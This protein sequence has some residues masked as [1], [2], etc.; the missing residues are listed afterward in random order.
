M[1]TQRKTGPDV[2]V[3][4]HGSIALLY[5]NRR[6][7]REWVAANVSDEAQFFGGALVVEPRYVADIIAGMRADGLE[8]E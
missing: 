2:W 6:A 7:A 8:V 5:L 3:I 4:N 1:S